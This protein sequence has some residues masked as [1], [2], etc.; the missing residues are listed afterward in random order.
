MI[1]SRPR[2]LAVDD[3]PGITAMLAALLP[4]C[5]VEAAT[6]G[7]HGLRM[8][9]ARPYDLYILDFDLPD[10]TAEAYCRSVR[11]SDPNAPIVVYTRR[12]QP[13]GMDDLLWSAWMIKSPDTEGLVQRVYQLLR[14]Q[15]LINESAAEIEVAAISEA[16][17][18]QSDCDAQL[19]A[20]IEAMG[21]RIRASW[22]EHCR[23][24]VML[25]ALSAYVSGGG[26]RSGFIDYW[27]DV[28]ETMAEPAPH[29]GVRSPQA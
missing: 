10:M 25:T 29:P 19:S 2:I 6:C 23:R 16:L 22:A 4:R 11:E 14:E 5:A 26:T 1:T 27:R 17:G 28:V 20:R 15:A 18:L 12:P 13:A 7:T 9:Q 3:F 24:G 21:H 8:A